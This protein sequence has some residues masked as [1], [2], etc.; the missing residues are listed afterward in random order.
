V[1][2]NLLGNGIVVAEDG[3][4]YFLHNVGLIGRHDQNSGNLHANSTWIHFQSPCSY[5][6]TIVPLVL[7]G[8]A[9]NFYKKSMS[10]TLNANRS[11]KDM[12]KLFR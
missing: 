2:G 3:T 1:H 8:K 12:G 9:D 7:L 10:G 5:N 11:K 4:K 6:P